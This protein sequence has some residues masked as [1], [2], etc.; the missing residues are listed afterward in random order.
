M[1]LDERQKKAVPLS[2]SVM[3]LEARES[4][5]A[6]IAGLTGLI[7]RKRGSAQS[8]ATKKALTE[9]GTLSLSLSLSLSARSSGVTFA[10]LGIAISRLSARSACAK[11]RKLLHSVL[12][13]RL[14]DLPYGGRLVEGNS[15]RLSPEK[16]GSP[17]GDR[18]VPVNFLIA[19]TRKA[20]NWRA[21]LRSI[22]CLYKFFSGDPTMTAVILRIPPAWPWHSVE[23]CSK[24]WGL[25]LS[26]VG[27]CPHR[28][29][30]TSRSRQNIRRI[31][32]G[33]QSYQ[34]F[35]S[36][37][38]SGIFGLPTSPPQARR[39][40][41]SLRTVDY[42]M[43]VI[44]VS[45]EQRRNE[46]A[47]EMGDPE[48][49]RRVNGI[50]RHDSHMQKLR[51]TRS[52][53]EPGS[54]WWE[55]SRLTVQPPWPRNKRSGSAVSL[56]ASHHGDPGSIP[57]RVTPDFRT[58]E[59]C[60]TMLLVDGFSRDLPFHMPFHSGAAPH[61]PSSTVKT[62]ISR[63][64]QISSLTNV[65]ASKVLT[66]LL[67]T[68][69]RICC[70][71]PSRVGEADNEIHSQ[72]TDLVSLTH[73]GKQRQK[74]AMSKHTLELLLLKCHSVGAEY[75]E[76]LFTS[77]V[78]NFT[79]HMPLIAPV[80]IYAGHC[81][82]PTAENY[83][84]GSTKGHPYGRIEC[85]IALTRKAL[86]F[87]SPTRR[88]KTFS[89]D[90]ASPGGAILS[91]LQPR[92]AFELLH[93]HVAHGVQSSRQIRAVLN[94]RVL[95]A[96]DDGTMRVREQ[97]RNARAWGNERSRENPPT[98]GIVR[99][100]SHM[101]KPAGNRTR[102]ALSGRRRHQQGP[103]TD[104]SVRSITTAISPRPT[105]I[106]TTAA[107]VEKQYAGNER[108]TLGPVFQAGALLP[109]LGRGGYLSTRPFKSPAMDFSTRQPG[110][111]IVIIFNPVFAA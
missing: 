10:T 40:F 96:D 25:I 83:T 35:N 11:A 99:H 65:R 54:P 3:S 67:A 5:M 73:E 111:A 4:L 45:M 91:F 20:L 86:H 87:F 94:I 39:T 90:H 92:G 16:R 100:D 106:N 60:R 8:W 19:S 1:Q 69:Q 72:L 77:I 84:R 75:M 101:R 7:E 43:R 27:N 42:P 29:E 32:N 79:G 81:L 88:Y 76:L 21:V 2:L 14:G 102:F 62:S 26:F 98:R 110:A 44:E 68:Y 33:I 57:G 41:V 18:D 31:Q 51:A 30:P 22:A 36:G 93:F 34:L 59:S 38:Q 50:V 49:N 95:R 52:G 53:I 109:Q 37:A 46:R 85:L 55:L 107:P 78:T 17:R 61:S 97:L 70:N 13:Y 104:V 74:R 82:A 80:E 58:W 47:G 89:G 63:A 23:V 24:S 15:A 12:R 64:A 103:I 48:K 56:L 28:H 66:L 9:D 108:R 6:E 105:Y 71:I